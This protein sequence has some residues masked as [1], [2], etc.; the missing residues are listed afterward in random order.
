[1]CP[2]LRSQTKRGDSMITYPKPVMKTSELMKM[3]FGRDY[4]LTVY[5]SPTQ[6][7]AW[8][9]DATKKNSPIFFDTEGF[10]AYRQEQIKLEQQ[11][12]K[13]RAAVM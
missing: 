12:K 4:L 3:G 13:R 7:F 6:N 8:K 11:A 10:E 2:R 5:A 1:M 9:Q